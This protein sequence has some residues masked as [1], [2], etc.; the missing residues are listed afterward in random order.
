MKP[1]VKLSE[2]TADQR[3]IVLALVAA[4]AAADARRTT[5]TQSKAA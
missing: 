3:R 1:A 2:L 5:P 4:K